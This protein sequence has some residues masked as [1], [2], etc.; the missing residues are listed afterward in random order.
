M[1]TLLCKWS[2][3]VVL[4]VT[5]KESLAQ[6]C[7]WRPEGPRGPGLYNMGGGP[8]RANASPAPP[9]RY[10]SLRGSIATSNT[11]QKMGVSFGELSQSIAQRN[12]MERCAS[13]DC[14]IDF[15]YR[16]QCVAVAWGATYSSMSSAMTV[17]EASAIS[18]KRCRK[19]T[20]DCQI[21]YTECSP[22]EQVP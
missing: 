8:C 6:S 14:R 7:Q 4:L 22:A 16:D 1:T 21:V 19:K 10:L 13:P 17:D 2:V 15:T 11:T 5:C 12:A 18:M 9:G 3:L 20:S